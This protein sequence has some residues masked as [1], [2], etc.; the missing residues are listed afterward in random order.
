MT[1][2]LV[3][4]VVIALLPRQVVP[5]KY[6]CPMHPDVRSETPGQCPLCRMDLVPIPP[7]RVGEY[8]MDVRVQ[9]TA[10]AV[11]GLT[12]TVRDPHSN[13]LVRNFA[14]VH[15]KLFHLFI[16]SR[17]LE[18]FAHV[19]P[20]QQSN[21]TFDLQHPLPPG[22]Y[23]LFADFLPADATSQLLQRAIVVPGTGDR[24]LPALD[25]GG[26]R[27]WIKGENLIPGKEGRLT[28]TL[29]DQ[30]TGAPITD[31]EPYL[32][33]AAHLLLVRSDLSDAVHEHPEEET[34]GGPTVSFHP[35][36]PAAGEYKLWLQVQ[37]RGRVLTFPFELRVA[38]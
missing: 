29:S 13:A 37:R 33:A 5:G 30:R 1:R 24:E 3:L 2:F 17:D 14:T 38:Q 36:I 35:V 7:L 23:M 20:T 16:V 31:L 22:E 25:D 32:G 15:D 26:V 34:A 11:T 27:V 8:R 6:W 18:Y 10:R 9:R 28:F 19:H 21:G 4:T 12:L